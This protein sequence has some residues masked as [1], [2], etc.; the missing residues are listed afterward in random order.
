MD[1]KNKLLFGML[2]VFLLLLTGGVV[3]GAS[4][5]SKDKIAKKKDA[6]L[7]LRMDLF[8]NAKEY[9]LNTGGVTYASDGVEEGDLE[10]YFALRDEAVK[11]TNSEK[12]EKGN[13]TVSFFTYEY[14]GTDE[15]GND[16]TQTYTYPLISDW[17]GNQFFYWHDKIGFVTTGLLYG[18]IPDTTQMVAVKNSVDFRYAYKFSGVTVLS[19]FKTELRDEAEKI[20][21]KQRSGYGWHDQYRYMVKEGTLSE[22][23]KNVLKDDSRLPRYILFVDCT[24]ELSVWKKNTLF[25]AG[26][27]FGAYLLVMAVAYVLLKNKKKTVEVNAE[28]EAEVKETEIISEDLA[29]IL[30]NKLESTEQSI[31]PNQYLE[32]IRAMIQDADKE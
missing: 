5:R 13:T 30:L 28:A 23:M 10:A 24:E 15:N 19:E 32:D 9:G 29:Q 8:F 25:N 31:G 20:I 1:K 22:A 18:D 27:A 17:F 26:V 4:L 11:R 6:E 2:A 21:D 16:V 12:T 3:L 7:E 14:E